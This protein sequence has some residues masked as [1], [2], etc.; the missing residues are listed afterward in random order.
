MSSTHI[1][2]VKSEQSHWSTTSSDLGDPERNLKLPV[3]L[4]KTKE[5]L[6]APKPG[7]L[8]SNGDIIVAIFRAFQFLPVG[9][10]CAVHVAIPLLMIKTLRPFDISVVAVS[11]LSLIWVVVAIFLRHIWSW[12]IVGVDAG[13]VVAWLVLYLVGRFADFDNQLGTTMSLA[14]WA[15]AASALVGA[16]VLGLHG[17]PYYMRKRYPHYYGLPSKNNVSNSLPDLLSVK[18]ILSILQTNRDSVVSNPDDSFQPSGG[19]LPTESM[20]FSAPKLHRQ[21]TGDQHLSSRAGSQIAGLSRPTTARIPEEVAA[22]PAETNMREAKGPLLMPEPPINQRRP[23]KGRMTG[24]SVLSEIIGTYANMGNTDSK[25]PIPQRNPGR[26]FREF[27]GRAS[28]LRK[29]SKPD[30]AMTRRETRRPHGFI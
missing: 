7:S 15:S 14:S 5:P 20:I 13:V 19:R 3:K 22:I 28:H 30:A 29:P 17:I 23:V 25:P 4:G 24:I 6:A 12:W 10:A 26:R 9:L 2:L 21:L 18:Y 16:I 11:G 8:G 27:A 1:T